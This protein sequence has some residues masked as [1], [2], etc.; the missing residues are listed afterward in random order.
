VK[1]ANVLI[2]RLVTNQVH[3]CDFGIA[4][5]QGPA[6]IDRKLTQAGAILGTPEYMSLEAFIGDTEVDHRVDVFALGITLF[7][8]LTGSVPVEGAVGAILR[9]RSQNSVPPLHQA[10]PDLSPQLVEI[11]VRCLAS[12]PGARFSTMSELAHALRS[13]T[14]EPLEELD[15]LRSASGRPGQQ[16]AAAGGVD[17]FALRRS[18]A[19][20]PY[21]TLAT[22]QRTGGSATDARIED[23]SE[24]GVLLVTKEPYARGE[25]VRLRFG[26]PI[27]GRVFAINGT[28]RWSRMARGTPATGVEFADL[29]D[30]ARLE[31]RQYVALMAANRAPK[32]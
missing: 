27:S 7:E 28:V 26:M 24:G 12:E 29:P 16:R 31:I 23:L 14:R 10:R 30:P 22:L 11:I 6:A 8:C 4:R 1:P 3:L 15:L 25:A 20:A 19:R 5:F 18:H 2:T 17:P 32:R 9:Q 13:C 21:V